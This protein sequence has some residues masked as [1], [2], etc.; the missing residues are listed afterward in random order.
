MAVIFGT[1]RLNSF[2]TGTDTSDTIYGLSG[3]DRLFGLGSDDRLFG[4]N[5]DDTFNVAARS[6]IS[7]GKT[8]DGGAGTDT[9]NLAAGVTLPV[10]AV[11][12]NV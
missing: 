3:S 5:G 6:E 7:D 8:N 12:A 9:L 11:V 10:G 4:G 1:A 2:L